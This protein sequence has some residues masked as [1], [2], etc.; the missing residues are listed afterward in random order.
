MTLADELRASLDGVQILAR[1]VAGARWHVGA[2][3]ANPDNRTLCGRW[4]LRSR[5]AII[6]EAEW[7]TLGDLRCRHCVRAMRRS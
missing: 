6:T 2:S 4:L 3:R 1:P 7:P 5:S